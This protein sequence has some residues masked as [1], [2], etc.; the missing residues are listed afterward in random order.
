[1]PPR[2]EP[3]GFSG[4]SCNEMLSVENDQVLFLK[5]LGTGLHRSAEKR[6]STEAAAEYYWEMLI[7][8]LQ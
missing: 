3:I 1:M 8:R 6:L 2:A 4:G 5:P 7:S